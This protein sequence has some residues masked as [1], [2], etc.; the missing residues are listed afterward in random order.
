MSNK[1]TPIVATMGIDIGKNSFHERA[2]AVRSSTRSTCSNLTERI[3][4][5]AL[6]RAQRRAERLLPAR[7]YT[8]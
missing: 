6:P 8:N 5:P 3:C 2:P 1:S 7:S 4:G